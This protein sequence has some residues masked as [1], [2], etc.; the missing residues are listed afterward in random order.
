MPLHPQFVTNRNCD[1]GNIL[2]MSLEE[3]IG[4]IITLGMFDRITGVPQHPNNMNQYVAAG[5]PGI[6]A[7]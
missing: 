3:R 7:Q 4:R 5:N 6:V 2:K 1:M